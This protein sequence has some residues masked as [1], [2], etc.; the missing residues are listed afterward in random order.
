MMA[1]SAVPSPPEERP[2]EWIERYFDNIGV[3]YAMSSPLSIETWLREIGS[4]KIG[5]VWYQKSGKTWISAGKF[6]ATDI[7]EP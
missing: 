4:I 5:V 1:G 3:L 2:K 6:K 7:Q